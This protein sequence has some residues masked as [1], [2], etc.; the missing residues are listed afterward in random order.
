MRIGVLTSGGDA[1]GMNAAIRAVVRAGIFRGSTVFGVR[2]GFL[3][4]MSGDVVPMDVGSVAD[5]IYRGGTILLTGRSDEFKSREGQQLAVNTLQDFGIEGLIVIGGDGSMRG[6]VE[7]AK[8]GI[9]VVA[10]PGTIDND[11]PFS[12]LSI[13]FDT[14]LNTIC[15]AVDKIRDTAEALE[16][17]FVVEVMGR[18]TGFLAL[19][20]GLAVGAESILLPEIPT[21]LDEVCLRL[22]RSRA[23]SKRHSIV[24]LAEGVGNAYDIAS[25]I[26]ERTGFPMRIIILGHIQRGGT[27]TALDRNLA[28][29][30]GAGAVDTLLAGRHGKLLGMH[31][32]CVQETDLAVALESRKGL[33]LAEY[34]LVKTLSI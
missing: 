16:R 24:I 8:R 30:L 28:S 21:D 3:G 19:A 11:V 34:E 15:Y 4:L 23:R 25:Q 5:I 6:C 13:G 33:N 26:T 22:R 31:N 32:G 29:R 17:T 18:D 7:L 12:E 20:S 9:R 2:R 14:A 1:P 27:P 10:I